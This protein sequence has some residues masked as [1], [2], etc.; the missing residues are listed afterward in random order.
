MASSQAGRD[1]YCY[2]VNDDL[3]V[4]MVRMAPVEGHAIEDA[5]WRSSFSTRV[6]MAVLD[7]VDDG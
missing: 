5:T 7:R 3:N 2:T 1:L 4:V 6:T